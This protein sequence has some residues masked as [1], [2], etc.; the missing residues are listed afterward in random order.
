MTGCA[1]NDFISVLL[2][3]LLMT[4]QEMATFAQQMAGPLRGQ[5]VSEP[6]ILRYT[7]YCEALSA[8]AAHLPCPFCFIAGRSA[9]LMPVYLR[10]GDGFVCRG[11][12]QEY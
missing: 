6:D 5:R 12:H 11:C 2:R 7:Q 9:T 1:P 4:R 8:D 3:E 10:D